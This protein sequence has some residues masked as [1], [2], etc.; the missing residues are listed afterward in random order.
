MKQRHP[1]HDN[2]VEDLLKD[3]PMKV[4]AH[5]RKASLD[6]VKTIAKRSTEVLRVRKFDPGEG[7]GNFFNR[8]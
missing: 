2:I 4:I 7:Q 1:Q 5:F 8:W 6:T 3:I